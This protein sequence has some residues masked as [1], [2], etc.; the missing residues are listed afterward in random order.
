MKMTFTHMRTGFMVSD[1]YVDKNSQ[2]L[3]DVW[4]SGMS[5][6]V[7]LESGGFDGNLFSVSKY[8]E[9]YANWTSI[10]V[11]ADIKTFRDMI[12]NREKAINVNCA[13]CNET[14]TLHYTEGGTVAGILEFMA[15]SFVQ[16]WHAGRDYN[17]AVPKG[18]LTPVQCVRLSTVLSVLGITDIDLWVLDVEGGEEAVLYSVDWSSVR[19]STIIMECD[20]HNVQKNERCLSILEQNGYTC[21]K[22]KN[23]CMCTHSSFSPS[24][25]FHVTKR[26]PSHSKQMR[27]IPVDRHQQRGHIDNFRAVPSAVGISTGVHAP[28]SA[29]SGWASPNSN[30]GSAHHHQ[31]LRQRMG[32]P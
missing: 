1:D 4:V 11:E 12:R 21:V 19:I 14:R 31:H 27:P 29:G 25:R 28:V 24:S 22:P 23:D 15:P 3:N 32:D 30:R 20:S 2:R 9:E 8:F 16:Q 6:G 5:N 7:I 13:L 17:E 10:L 26:A 18:K